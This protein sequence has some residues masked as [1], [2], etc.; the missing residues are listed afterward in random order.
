MWLQEL[1]HLKKSNDLIG[2][3]TPTSRLNQLRY[4]VPQLM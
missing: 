2:N 4:R 1:G 3:R